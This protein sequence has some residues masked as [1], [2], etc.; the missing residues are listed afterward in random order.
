MKTLEQLS[1][2]SRIVDI[3]AFF[4]IADTAGVVEEHGA[5]ILRLW[6]HAV[7]ALDELR[8][9]PPEPERLRCYAAALRG[10]YEAVAR[11]ARHGARGWYV[12][13]GGA[14]GD[15]ARRAS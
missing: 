9:Q 2:L 14:R 3:L 12:I 13:E 15:P 6:A 11:P 8:P 4:G 10:A 1:N 7:A 5:T